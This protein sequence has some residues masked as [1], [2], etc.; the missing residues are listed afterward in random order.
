MIR[1]LSRRLALVALGALVALPSLAHADAEDDALVAKAVAYLDGLVAEKGAF[2]QTDQRGDQVT[3]TFYLARPGRAR[4]EYNPPSSLLIT[5]DGKTVIVSDSR[6]KT[7]Q[8]MPLSST[9]LGV[10]LSEHIRLDRGAK[11]VRVD[12]SP[13]G[14]SITAR[15]SR[16]LA[17]GQVTLYFNQAPMRLAGWAI[18]DARGYTTRVALGALSPLANPSPDLFTQT[19]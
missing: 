15:D 3:G 19:Q 11:V 2:Q 17:Q 9:P 14:F 6:L 5:S 8:R 10:F 7:F 13:G 1:R 12:R 16:A 18:T 4:F